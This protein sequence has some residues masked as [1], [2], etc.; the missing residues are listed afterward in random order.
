MLRSWFRIRSKLLL[1]FVI[2]LLYNLPLIL[3]HAQQAWFDDG[4][5]A[6]KAIEQVRLVIALHGHVAKSFGRRSSRPSTTPTIPQEDLAFKKVCN[7]SFK[8]GSVLSVPTPRIFFKLSRKYAKHPC[9]HALSSCPCGGGSCLF[10]KGANADVSSNS[11][12]FFII[13]GKRERREEQASRV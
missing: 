6:D 7:K 13:S 11:C 10:R 9:F 3:K 12:L 2:E 5:N 1:R 8:A 4:I